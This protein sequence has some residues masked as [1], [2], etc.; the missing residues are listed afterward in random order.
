MLVHFWSDLFDNLVFILLLIHHCQAKDF[1]HP[2]IILCLI[3]YSLLDFIVVHFF[4][5]L[6]CREIVQSPALH[7]DGSVFLIFLL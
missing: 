5:H 2:E 1:A 6:N 3:L 4:K 7:L